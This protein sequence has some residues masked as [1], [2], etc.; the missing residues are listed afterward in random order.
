MAA[1]ITANGHVLSANAVL[2]TR[3]TGTP[4]GT[5]VDEDLA[6]FLSEDGFVRR[7]ALAS[8][9][10]RVETTGLSHAAAL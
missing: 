6:R 10:D 1:L 9:V 2:R 4:E 3:A 8:G 5:I 7:A